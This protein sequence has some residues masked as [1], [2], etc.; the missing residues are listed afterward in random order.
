MLVIHVVFYLL[1]SACEQQERYI[2]CFYLVFICHKFWL[3]TIVYYYCTFNSDRSLYT[4]VCLVMCNNPHITAMCNNPHQHDIYFQ[5]LLKG[6]CAKLSHAITFVYAH[7]YFYCHAWHLYN[8]L[9]YTSKRHKYENTVNIIIQIV[10][11][12]SLNIA[13]VTHSLL[14]NTDSVVYFV[15]SCKYQYNPLLLQSNSYQ[16]NQKVGL[17]E[18]L[19]II[20]NVV[21]Q[22]HN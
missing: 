14:A 15:Q 2:L 13:F 18:Q 19:S 11:C 1:V 10:F 20:S 17:L 16:S 4:Y 21:F 8:S 5:S 7:Q 9:L 6:T 3:L 22:I 12:F